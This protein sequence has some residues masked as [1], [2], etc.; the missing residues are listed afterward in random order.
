MEIGMST[1]KR[2]DLSDK[3]KLSY[4]SL[5]ILYLMVEG[6][7]TIPNF[8]GGNLKY[9]E[10]AVNLLE[11]KQLIVQTE[12]ITEGKKILGVKVKK[13]DVEWVFEPTDKGRQ[14]VAQQRKNYRKFLAFYDVFAHVDPMTGE[15]AFSKIKKLLLEK[16]K[17]AWQ[18]YKYQ[19]R[20]VDYRVPVFVYKG[21]DP[22]EF[23]FFSFMEEGR[24]VPTENDEEHE[25][26]RNLFLETL[27]E[28]IYEVLNTAPIWEE[29]GDENNPAAEIMETIIIE[30]AKVLKKQNKKLLKFIKKQD[31]IINVANKEIEEIKANQQMDY[32]DYYD[33]PVRYN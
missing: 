4:Q 13:E 22:R 19:D 23:I 31:E 16:G 8:L 2:W 28:E 25:W 1:P 29:Q 12:N 17:E 20:W 11:K 18:N 7:V 27:W 33:D 10:E 26:A 9:V 6:K 5:Y 21:I 15:F 24:F 30:G 3:K 32:D 14:V